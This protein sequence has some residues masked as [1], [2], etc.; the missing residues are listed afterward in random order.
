MEV[1]SLKKNEREVNADFLYQ[2]IEKAHR[3]QLL[4][5]LYYLSKKGIDAKGIINYPL[6]RKTVQEELTEENRMEIEKVLLDIG[7]VLGMENAPPPEM[8]TYCKRCS[9]YEL[10]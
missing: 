4:Y 1:G 5:Y 7:S 3:Y 6:L 8:K 9:Y 10:C 2:R